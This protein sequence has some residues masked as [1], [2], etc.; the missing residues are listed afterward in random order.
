MYWRRHS[1]GLVSPDVTN[2]LRR[3]CVAGVGG[4]G[5]QAVAGG[6]GGQR[7]GPEDRRCGREAEGGQ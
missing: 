1:F 7:E 3:R 4:E 5:E 6:P 2:G